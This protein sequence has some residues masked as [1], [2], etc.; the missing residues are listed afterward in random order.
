MKKDFNRYFVEEIQKIV[1]L[2]QNVCYKL[3]NACNCR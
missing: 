1:K 3:F 2:S